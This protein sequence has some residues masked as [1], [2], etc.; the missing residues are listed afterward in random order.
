MVKTEKEKRLKRFRSKPTNKIAERIDRAI[1]QR[2]F[3]I[4]TSSPTTCSEHG[5]PKITLS[6]LGSTGNIYEVTISKIPHCNCPDHAKGN[7]CKHLLFVMLKV[8]GLSVSSHLVYQSAYLEEELQSIVTALQGRLQ[9]RLGSDVVANEA[10]RQRHQHLKNCGDE[11]DANANADGDEGKVAAVVQRQDIEG[12]D[13]PICFDSLGSTL[14]TFCQQTCGT[15]FHSACMKVWT[16]QPSQRNNPT[17][18]NC[19]QPWVDGNTMSACVNRKKKA[20]ARGD[21][22]GYEN[23]GDLQGQSRVRDTS[24]YASNDWNGGYDGGYKKRRY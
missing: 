14:L 10:V 18:P 4:E 20:K 1:Q 2:L 16:N 6:V 11:P 23:L 19:R 15:N 13:C 7:I 17:C 3:L 8:A 21:S 22:E 24:T 12:N 9:Q 5:G